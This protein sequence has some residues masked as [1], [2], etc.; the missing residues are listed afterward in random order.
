MKVQGIQKPKVHQR[1]EFLILLMIVQIALDIAIM[2][3]H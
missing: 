2:L 3:K 1:P